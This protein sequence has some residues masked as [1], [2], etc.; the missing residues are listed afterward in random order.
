QVLLRSSFESSKTFW[1]RVFR[2]LL[3]FAA[4][5]AALLVLWFWVPPLIWSQGYEGVISESDRARWEKGRPRSMQ[6][7][8]G[9]VRLRQVSRE[10]A[11]VLLNLGGRQQGA[12]NAMRLPNRIIGNN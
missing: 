1:M 6:A 10:G 11:E 3:V 4:W 7:C 2:P 12:W 9:V 8:P 5:G